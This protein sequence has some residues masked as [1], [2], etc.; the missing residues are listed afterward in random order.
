[1]QDGGGKKPEFVRAPRSIIFLAVFA[2]LAGCIL[3]IPLQHYMPLGRFQHYGTGIFVF[4]LGYLVQGIANWPS[5]PNLAKA[6]YLATTTFFCSIGYLFMT[7]PWLDLRMCT[8]GDEQTSLRY[9]I[10]SA[11]GVAGLLVVSLWLLLAWREFKLSRAR[12]KASN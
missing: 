4:G 7:N 10:L 5:I 11:Y 3:C 12:K 2:L 6:G 8:T 9:N 1:M